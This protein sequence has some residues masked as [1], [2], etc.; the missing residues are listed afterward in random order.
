MLGLAGCRD[1]KPENLAPSASAL[2]PAR[3]AA[4][5]SVGFVI[6]ASSSRVSFLMEAP[7]EKI[8]GE[9]PGSLE[10]ELYLDAQ[11]LAKSTGLVKVDLDQLT[12]YHQKRGDEQSEFGERVKDERQNRHARAWLEIED[13]APAA[14][15]RANRFAEFRIDR[16]EAPSVASLAALSGAERKFTA[17]AV[18]ELRVHERKSAQRAKAE[19]TVLSAG[20]TP[21]S[22]R[23]RLLEPLPVDLEQYD[24][25]PREA[26]GKLAKRT[27]A[28]LG[29]EVAKVAPIQ[30][31][32]SARAK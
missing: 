3:A 26:F 10:G 28:A 22:L 8:F 16:L 4:T 21:K 24:V 6:E 20:D 14:V 11:D 25:R 23:V 7:I 15:R 17:V 27:L 13:D 2:S 30:V 1:P 31:E 18:G 32:L 29:S 19:I 12:L 9:A 5:G